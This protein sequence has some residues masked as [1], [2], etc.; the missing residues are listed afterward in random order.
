MKISTY[1]KIEWTTLGLAL[2]M[3]LLVII[4]Q[5]P[6]FKT[7]LFSA[8]SVPII[9]TLSL[10]LFAISLYCQVKPKFKRK[11]LFSKLNYRRFCYFIGLI[12]LV[13]YAWINH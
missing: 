11:D 8:R 9:L 10:V 6:Q 5:S 2:A 4:N 1:K 7:L 3:I 12:I 13:V